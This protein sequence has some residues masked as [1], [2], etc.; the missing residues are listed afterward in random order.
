MPKDAYYFSHDSNARND[1]K[2]VK[3]RQ[4]LGLE[5]YGLYWCVIEMLRESSKYELPIEDIPPICFELRID[6]EKFKKL[7]DCELLFKGKKM[8]YSKSLKNRMLRLDEIKQKRKIAGA[9]G[10]KCKANAK[11][12]LSN[13]EASKVKQSIV[14]NNIVNNRKVF[15][16]NV[17]KESKELGFKKEIWEPFCQYWTDIDYESKLMQWQLKDNFAINSKLKS[18]KKLSQSGNENWKEELKEFEL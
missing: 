4:S 6:E 14:N 13:S 17:I 16:E 9:K 1:L 2:I 8:F 3:L 15:I 18:W 5:G 10:G 12:M 11:Q 7:F